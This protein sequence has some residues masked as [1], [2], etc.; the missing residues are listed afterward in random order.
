MDKKEMEL[1]LLLGAIH[2]CANELAKLD[3]AFKQKLKG[4]DAVI[5][6]KSVPNGPNFYAIIKDQKI[7]FKTDAIHKNPTFTWI[8]KDVGQAITIFKGIYLIS[9][10]I[11]KGDVEV[12]GD[13]AKTLQLTF[14]LEDL[15]PYLGE[16]TG[17]A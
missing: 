6:W 14:Y 1:T 2:Y 12:I 16:L 13:K 3:P 15:V 9:N 11:K 10:A 17:S 7:E 4:I 5:Q 8:G